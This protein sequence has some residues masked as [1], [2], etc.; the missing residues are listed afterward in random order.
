VTADAARTSTRALVLGGG[1]LAGIAWEV[2]VLVALTDAG[3]D[4]GRADRIVGT[5]AGSV[6]GTLLAT[7]VDLAEVHAQHQDADASAG[8][9]GPPVT[10]DMETMGAEIAGAMAGARDAREVRARIGAWASSVDTAPETERRTV[11]A[12]RLPVRDW[13][14]RDLRITAVDAG[15]GD[16]VVFT[17]AGA[18]GPDGSVSAGVEL[19]DAV[20]ASCA[21]PGVWPPVTIDGHRY[22]DGGMASI[23]HVALADE[24][25][26]VDRVL[27]VAPLD[28]PA[29]GPFASASEEVARRREALGAEGVLGV[30][31]DEPSLAAFGA[32]VLDPAVMPASAR[33]G[34]AQGQAVAEDV[35]RLWA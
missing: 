9:A 7:G 34:Y 32:N 25:D 28:P 19:V 3:V 33:A 29:G 4:L 31:A 22:I 13:P 18:Q 23:V 11:I 30:L 8:D 6:V 20:A 24:P 2:G 26:P 10:L 12:G 21:V 1:G 5:S 16:R 35:V 14:D 17:S 15:S 27:V